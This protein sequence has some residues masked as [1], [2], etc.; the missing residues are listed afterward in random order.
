MVL[1]H[2]EAF[3]TDNHSYSITDI[4]GI[5]RECLS[6]LG[7]QGSTG[8]QLLERRGSEYDAAVLD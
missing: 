8:K 5:V 2:F 3:K 6:R 4:V 1:S 7:Y